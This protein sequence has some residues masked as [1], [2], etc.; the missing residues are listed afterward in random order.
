MHP[1]LPTKST[2][3]RAAEGFIISLINIS[4]DHSG[5]QSPGCLSGQITDYE[6]YFLTMLRAKGIDLS[7]DVVFLPSQV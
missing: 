7:D 5:S 1:G 3:V 6:N 4:N 2:L